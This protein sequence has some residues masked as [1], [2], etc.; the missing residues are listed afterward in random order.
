LWTY[1]YGN[2]GGQLQDIVWAVAVDNGYG[3]VGSWGNQTQNNPQV[4]VFHRSSKEPIYTYYTPGSIFD[5]DILHNG[6]S[7]NVVAGCKGTH[8]N[9]A[10]RGGFLYSFALPPV[11]NREQ[12]P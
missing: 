12:L 4:R 5:V 6:K 10:G 3:V 11:Q 1:I 8:A 9:I 7:I 2:A